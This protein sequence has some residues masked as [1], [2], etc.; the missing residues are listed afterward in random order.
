MK[1]KKIK[2]VIHSTFAGH[3]TLV[4]NKVAGTQDLV[5]CEYLMFCSCVILYLCNADKKK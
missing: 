1:K 2:R 4:P 3:S 5:I